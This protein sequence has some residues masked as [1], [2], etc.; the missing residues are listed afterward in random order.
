MLCFERDSLGNHHLVELL[1]VK[2]FKIDSL[3]LFTRLCVENGYRRGSW[4]FL[5][6]GS[7]VFRLKVPVYEVLHIGELVQT[8][9]GARLNDRTV[10]L[11]VLSPGEGQGQETEEENLE[12]PH[13]GIGEYQSDYERTTFTKVP[14][15]SPEAI[16][17]NE[18]GEEV[19]RIAIDK[20][21]R[22]EL[23]D[24][25]VEKGIPKKEKTDHDEI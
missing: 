9:S 5:K 6:N 16:F 11:L 1:P 10:D 15:K 7:L 25:M 21:K 3:K 24:L 13:C 18:A 14:G 20:Y 12:C 17:F 23:N 19:E 8:S 22:S 2:F 4:D